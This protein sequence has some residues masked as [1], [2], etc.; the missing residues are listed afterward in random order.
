MAQLLA[1]GARFKTV[2]AIKALG[3]LY[4]TLDLAG[5]RTG[6]LNAGIMENSRQEVQGAPNC[7]VSAGNSVLPEIAYLNSLPS[8]RSS[9]T[10]SSSRLT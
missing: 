10:A 5:Y 2:E 6:S 7:L 9:V 4:V 8:Y 1:G 3:Y